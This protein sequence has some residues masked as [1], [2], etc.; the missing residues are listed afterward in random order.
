[1]FVSIEGT[2]FH[3]WV[4]DTSSECW[5][6]SAERISRKTR[7]MKSNA[8]DSVFTFLLQIA[9]FILSECFFSANIL[10]L[11]R[12]PLELKRQVDASCSSIQK[13]F[14]RSLARSFPLS[15]LLVTG[16]VSSSSLGPLKKWYL[17]AGRKAEGKWKVR[18]N[19]SS[20]GMPEIGPDEMSWARVYVDR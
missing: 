16:F 3:S 1:M 19:E 8:R 12:I 4:I 6:M 2:F 17:S 13:I 15:K 20:S 14:I 7:K 5:N 9:L 11:R 18:M 10:W